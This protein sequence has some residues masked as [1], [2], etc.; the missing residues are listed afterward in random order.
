ME[1]HSLY[2]LSHFFAIAFVM[3]W[4]ARF[5]LAF[6]Y[7]SPKSGLY[8]LLAVQR[9]SLKPFRS[10]LPWNNLLLSF[11]GLLFGWVVISWIEAWFVYKWL[12]LILPALEI[13]ATDQ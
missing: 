6:Y 4:L 2:L 3:A 12:L 9:V 5:G 13:F 1:I 7:W 8:R 11:S 10:R